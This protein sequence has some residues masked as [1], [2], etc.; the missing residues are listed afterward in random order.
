MS[1]LRKLSVA[2]ATFNEGKNIGDCLKSVK[3]IAD[4][5]VVVDGR[6]GDNTAAIAK[7][8][9]ARVIFAENNP[10]FHINKNM[11]IDNCSGDWVLLLD[12]DER[13]SQE[14]RLEIAET[15]RGEG[16]ESAYW[17][18]RRNWFL[19][20]FLKKGG[21]YPDSVIRLFRKGIGRLPELSV[22]E[23]VA[24]DGKLGNLKHDLI[25]LADPNFQRYL[26]RAQRY[27]TQT[28]QTFAKRRK[29]ATTANLLQFS[30]FIPFWVFCKI[31]FR[32]RGYAD[33]FAGFV[34]ALFSAFHYFYAFVKYWE[35]EE[36]IAQIYDLK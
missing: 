9:G 3:G 31:Y 11:A 1:K 35:K 29:T 8:A 2:I 32:H 27:T 6:S 24:V 26:I 28:S 33:G 10:M 12:A 18:N 30:I 16:T 17:I 34:W 20:R 22:H 13:V 25:H 5:I 15:I 21:V 19:G 36:K 23:Q 7:E 14:L 4:E